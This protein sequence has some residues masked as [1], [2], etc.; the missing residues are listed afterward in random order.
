MLNEPE[1]REEIEKVFA[2]EDVVTVLSILDNIVDPFDKSKARGNAPL[3]VIKAVLK[4]SDG[5]IE[6][7][8]EMV[9][10]ANVDVRNVLMWAETP[11][12]DRQNAQTLTKLGNWLIEQGKV[13]QGKTLLARAEELKKNLAEHGSPES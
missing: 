2:H 12:S 4:L 3:R 9:A 6:K 10:E 7:L 1:V 11:A 5:R 13:D 8:Q